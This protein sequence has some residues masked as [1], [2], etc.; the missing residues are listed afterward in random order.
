MYKKINFLILVLTIPYILSAAG[1][2]E[3]LW[4]GMLRTD[5]IMIPF[6]QFDGKT[7]SKCWVAPKRHW[8]VEMKTL[9]DIPADW[10]GKA[11]YFPAK[12][13]ISGVDN[14]D[15]ELTALNAVYTKN[16]CIEMHGIT[17][18]SKKI[19]R[20]ECDVC[21][22]QNIAFNRDVDISTPI[23]FDQDSK[24][25]GEILE[26]LKLVYSDKSGKVQGKEDSQS[27]VYKNKKKV[28]EHMP[29]SKSEIEKKKWT[30]FHLVEVVKDVYY[31]TAGWL[32]P[33]SDP[34]DPEMLGMNCWLRKTGNRFEILTKTVNKADEEVFNISEWNF[35][36]EK[37][38][39]IKKTKYII[40]AI[41][42]YE[43]ERYV[44]FKIDK[45]VFTVMI[46]YF[47]G[48]C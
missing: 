42:G 44:V 39:T 37:I 46:K 10:L 28:I 25:A 14:K 3:P 22:V 26:Y 47:S 31:L 27:E 20:T 23:L 2:I 45:D 4:A 43:D 48:G 7:W 1:K 30:H 33:Q 6:A 40:A 32:N 13:F 16:H 8:Q 41:S 38:L 35:Y 17:L 19:R 24:I 12:W 21:G 15:I 5:G 18:D 34:E 36:A 11:S 9:N 29:F